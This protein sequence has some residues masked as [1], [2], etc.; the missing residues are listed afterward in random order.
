MLMNIFKRLKLYLFWFWRSPKEV[1][2]IYENE[3]KR[4]EDN[5][6]WRKSPNKVPWFPWAYYCVAHVDYTKYQWR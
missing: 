2:K 3:I 1:R 4:I 6:K 5:A